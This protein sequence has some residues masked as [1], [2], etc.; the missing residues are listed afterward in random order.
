MPNLRD[1]VQDRLSLSPPFSVV[2]DVFGYRHGPVPRRSMSLRRQLELLEGLSLDI[3]IIGVGWDNFSDNDREEINYGLQLAREIYANVDLCIRRIR[4]QQ[5]L[6]ANAGGYT[7]IN[8]CDEAHDLTDDF[9]G[10]D[11][12][13]LDVFVVRTATFPILGCSAVV[14]PCDKDHAWRMTGSVVSLSGNN[15]QTGVCF[16]H[17]I[18]HY[19]GASGDEPNNHSSDPSNFMFPTI[20]GTNTAITNAQGDEMKSHCYLEG[21][22][23]DI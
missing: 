10:P 13:Y 7:T 3:N 21:I 4:W 2:R 6:A 19:L 11:G 16:A 8:S 23:S 17:E 5:I 20:S 18:G 9:N 1:I 15:D 22:F 14:G 12:G